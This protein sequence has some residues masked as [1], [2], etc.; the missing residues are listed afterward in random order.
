M[1]TKWLCTGVVVLPFLL[2]PRPVAA[3]QKLF[4]DAVEVKV[5]SVE[6]VVEDDDGK[7]ISGLSAADFE[8]LED[9]VPQEVA[10]FSAIEGGKTL[11]GEA[12]LTGPEEGSPAMAPTDRLH[13][14]IFIDESHLEPQNRN[15]V[16]ANLES[17]LDTSLQPTDLV[18]IARLTD[19]LIIEQPFT[20]DVAAL[21]ATL[22][23]LS[24]GAGQALQ[25]SATYRRILREVASTTLQSDDEES[26]IR[27]LKAQQKISPSDAI[28][29]DARTQARDIAS[30]SEER[31][32]R[33]NR[34]LRAMGSAVSSLAGLHGRKA[35][36]YLSDGLPVRAAES[37]AEAWREKYEQWAMHNDKRELISELTR[38]ASMSIE[39]QTELDQFAQAAAAARVAIYALS[40][41]SSAA[42]GLGG[43]EI[44]GSASSGASIARTA[45]ITESFEGESPLLQMA[46]TTGG[47]ARTRNSD[48]SALLSGVRE[49]FGSFYSLGYKPKTEAQDGQRKIVVKLR[50]HKDLNVR[51]TRR[52]SD[53]DPVEQLRELTLSALY[54]GLVDNPLD[55]ELEGKPA[56][57]IGG[58]KYR[59]DL[60]VKIPFEKLLLLPQEKNHVGRLTLFVVV[61]DH[62]T[63]NLSSMNRIELPLDIPN[64]QIL[65]AMAQKAA[66]PLKLEMQGGPQRLA[67]G[68]R[69]HLARV[70]ATVEFDVDVPSSL[71]LVTPPAAVPVATPEGAPTGGAR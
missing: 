31:R 52:L 10:Y 56:E 70:S 50:G 25:E 41:G 43:A 65:S 67:I 55:I 19:R 1:R 30:F 26:D 54:H 8:I 49:D 71:A 57:D 45:S 13:L 39:S 44:S 60:L 3:Q 16:F 34:T 18:L 14:A 5:A 32:Q 4:F 22:A 62:K 23:R 58:G 28:E 2:G 11:E 53:Q 68:V 61:Q 24:N 6:V 21:K 42:R 27:S 9:G 33:V 63:Q 15:R 66:Y 37:L 29:I 48:I 69:D 46:E 17:Y 51:Y 59:V 36:I 64:E 40:P 47:K 7:K 35:L 20:N 38:A 12:S